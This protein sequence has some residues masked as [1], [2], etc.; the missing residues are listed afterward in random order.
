M[1]CIFLEFISYLIVIWRLTIF[2]ISIF[3][4]NPVSVAPFFHWWIYLEFRV[5]PVCLIF[6][7]VCIIQ[8]L[9]FFFSMLEFDQF[10]LFNSLLSNKMSY[11][12]SIRLSSN[13]LHKTIKIFRKSR[14]YLVAKSSAIFKKAPFHFYSFEILNVK[15]KV[16]FRGQ[17]FAVVDLQKFGQKK[18]AFPLVMIR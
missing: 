8:N 13:T 10:L 9:C 4:F 16:M 12:I 2:L 5:T 15:L 17:K 11:L 1:T 6:K 14:M 3:Y 18:N 7:N